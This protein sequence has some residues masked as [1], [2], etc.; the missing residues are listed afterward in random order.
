MKI[1]HKRYCI[2]CARPIKKRVSE[3]RVQPISLD[4]TANF[5]TAH[6]NADLRTLDDCRRHTNA[7]FIISTRRRDGDLITAFTTWDGESYVDQYFCRNVCAVRQGYAAASH[8]HRFTW[9]G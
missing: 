5:M 8:G 3:I 4:H 9:R 2:V 6:I 7:P 1:P